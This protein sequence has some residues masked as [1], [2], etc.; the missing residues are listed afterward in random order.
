MSSSEL[1]LMAAIDEIHMKLPFYGIRRIRGELADRGFLVGRG[2]VATLMR[3]M[4]IEAI[5]PKRRLSVPNPGA[6][7]SDAIGL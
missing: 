5:H 3:R 1:A 7:L 4:G 6:A 2:H